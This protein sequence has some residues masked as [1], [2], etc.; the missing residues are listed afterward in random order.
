[1]ATKTEARAWLASVEPDLRRG[2]VVDSRSGAERF[3]NYAQ[4]WFDGRNLRPRTRETYESQLTWILGTFRNT[5]LRDVDPA[6]VRSW[7]G[8]MNRAGLSPN[9]VANVYRLL[10]T[11]MTMAINDGLLRTNPVAIKGTAARGVPRSADSHL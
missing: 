2:D 7:C 4:Q 1:M 6:S 5:R 10:R 3:G 8:R 9:T 11:I